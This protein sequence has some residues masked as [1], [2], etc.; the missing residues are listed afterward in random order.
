MICKKRAPAQL[1]IRYSAL[2]T[3]GNAFPGLIDA[4]GNSDVILEEHLKEN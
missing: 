4:T 2:S 3:P 1:A